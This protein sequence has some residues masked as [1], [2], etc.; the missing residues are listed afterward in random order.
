M[1]GHNDWSSVFPWTPRL[2]HNLVGWTVRNAG[3]P[4]TLRDCLC[5]LCPDFPWESAFLRQGSRDT[6]GGNIVD[7]PKNSLPQEA[8]PALDKD[9]W[10]EETKG[11]GFPSEERRF[12]KG[13]GSSPAAPNVDDALGAPSGSSAGVEG[14]PAT[15]ASVPLPR[16]LVQGIEPPLDASIAQLWASLRHPDH[17]LYVVL[18][19]P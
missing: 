9:H 10:L 13:M 4:F 17:F 3:G 18:R 19:K 12:E 6:P 5:W 7:T 15:E 16:V 1:I 8:P 14:S 11:A 2:R